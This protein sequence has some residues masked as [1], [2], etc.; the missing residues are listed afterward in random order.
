[1]ERLFRGAGPTI[2]LASAIACA[3]QGVRTALVARIG[4]DDLGRMAL[5]L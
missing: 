1:L 5:D 3:R 4:R 2:G